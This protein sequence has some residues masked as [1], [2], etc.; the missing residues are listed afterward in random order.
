MSA[1]L[2]PEM[3]LA[4]LAH[5]TF[6]FGQHER[7]AVQGF[8]VDAL[9]NAMAGSG[10]WSEFEAWMGTKRKALGGRSPAA[11]IARGFAST[12]RVRCHVVA[13]FALRGKRSNPGTR[14]S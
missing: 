6:Y 13:S 5:V 11:C 2:P 14:K 4:G 9:F 8:V 3:I 1:N 12:A 7:Y 10:D